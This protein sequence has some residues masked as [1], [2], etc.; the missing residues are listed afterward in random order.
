[1][2]WNTGASSHSL[3]KKSYILELLQTSVD[4]F[5]Y[6]KLNQRKISLLVLHPSKQAREVEEKLIIIDELIAGIE[7]NVGC[8]NLKRAL[9]FLWVLQEQI[10]QSQIRLNDI[11]FYELVS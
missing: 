3:Y 10:E 2:D 7:R 5:Y 1:M 4:D 11:D 6:N 9:H 8:G